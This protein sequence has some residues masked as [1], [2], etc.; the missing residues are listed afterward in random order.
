MRCWARSPQWFRKEEARKHVIVANFWERCRL[1]LTKAFWLWE[2]ISR[3]ILL[4]YVN[5]YLIFLPELFSPLV[6]GNP[7]LMDLSGFDSVF[8]ARERT[9]GHECHWPWKRET[10]VQPEMQRSGNFWKMIGRHMP[11]EI[12]KFYFRDIEWVKSLDRWHQRRVGQTSGGQEA[13][14][15]LWGMNVGN[16]RS[17]YEWKSSDTIV[18]SA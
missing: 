17:Y 10:W 5:R 8:I 12:R 2:E 16:E 14:Q 7:L 18:L 11:H 13:W 4:L 3:S 1:A 6:F 15:P 9:S